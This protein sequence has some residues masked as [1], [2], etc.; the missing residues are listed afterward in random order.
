M[1]IK[2]LVMIRVETHRLIRSPRR[3]S[4]RQCYFSDSRVGGGGPDGEC[5]M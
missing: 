5:L 2:R 4:S 3:E 1:N